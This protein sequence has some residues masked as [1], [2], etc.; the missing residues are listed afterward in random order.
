MKH[1]LAYV[2]A[3]FLIASAIAFVYELIPVSYWR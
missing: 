2:G 1:V 3:V